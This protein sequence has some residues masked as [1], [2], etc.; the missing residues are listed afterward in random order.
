MRTYGVLHI[1]S[2]KVPSETAVGS[3]MGYAPNP[4]GER[5]GTQ[6]LRDRGHKMSSNKGSTIAPTF[7][8]GMQSRGETREKVGYFKQPFVMIPFDFPPAL[9]SPPSP[10]ESGLSAGKA[11]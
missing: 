8:T 7:R 4:K 2:Q 11:Y 1:S 3:Q 6:T 10:F 9:K 5:Q